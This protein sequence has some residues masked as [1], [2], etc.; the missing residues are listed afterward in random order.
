[1]ND[2]PKDIQREQVT[3]RLKESVKLAED[4]GV[5]LAIENH[6]D[7]L[8]EDIMMMLEEV[9]S[10]NLGV[11]YDTGNSLRLQEEPVKAA[12]LLAPHIIATH[13]KDVNPVYGGDPQDWTFFASVPAGRGIVNLPGVIRA[14]E[15][16]GYNGFYA[17]ELDYL[18]PDFNDEFNVAEESIQFLREL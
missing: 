15:S 18:H 3:R 13:I 6:Q 8:A 11:N 5:K 17:I 2:I 12:T 10:P 14:I 4:C 16:A 1:M 9:D 7:F